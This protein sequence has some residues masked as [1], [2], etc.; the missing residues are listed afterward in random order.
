MGLEKKFKDQS[1]LNNEL[2]KRIDCSKNDCS[3]FKKT[4]EKNFRTNDE[5]Y[6]TKVNLTSAVEELNRYIDAQILT[7][8]KKSQCGAD[9]VV[10]KEFRE[11]YRKNES[12]RN[13]SVDEFKHLL[14]HF[15]VALKEKF[16]HK[17]AEKMQ[18]QLDSVPSK[19]DLEKFSFEAV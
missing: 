14:D 6:C 4:V 7:C 2:E 10:V 13:V 16:S 3:N 19:E 12:H 15:G 9:F 11:L 18:Q 8:S 1:E 17:E 5:F